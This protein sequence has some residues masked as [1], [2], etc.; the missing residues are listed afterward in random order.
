MG[1]LDL[2]AT[3][4]LSLDRGKLLEAIE[5]L[6]RY[7]EL[8]G[9]ANCDEAWRYSF[10]RIFADGR[11]DIAEAELTA[12]PLVGGLVWF[13]DGEPWRISRVERVARA[14]STTPHEFFACGLAA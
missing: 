4:L 5:C 10:R 11:W 6:S 14:V 3:A 1:V 8:L 12:P 7:V 9:E 2:A 13:E